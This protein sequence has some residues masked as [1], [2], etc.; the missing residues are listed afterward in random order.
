[1]KKSNLFTPKILFTVFF[2][3][4]FLYAIGQNSNNQL[5]IP[6]INAGIAKLSGKFLNLKLSDKNE[7]VKIRIGVYNPI[8]GESYYETSLSQNFDFNIDIPLECSSAIVGLS[9]QSDSTLLE[10]Y[11]IGVLKDKLSEIIID[12][13]NK[14]KPIINLK[15]GLRLTQNDMTSIGTGIQL[16]ETCY[17]WADYYKMTPTEFREYELN[18][19]L[20][21]RIKF[22][23]DSF[24]VSNEIINYLTN[25][26]NLRYFD[27]LI[28]DYKNV[29]QQSFNYANKDS[30]LHYIVTEPDTL[31]YSFLKDYNLNNPQYL[32]CYSYSSFLKSFLSIKSLNIPEIKD[33]QIDA[34]LSVVKSKIKNIV[35]FDSGLF[36]DMLIANS[37]ILQMNYKMKPLTNKQ[38]TNIQDYFKSKNMDIASILIKSN[39]IIKESLEKGQDLKVNATPYVSKEKL[40]NAIISKY[41]GKVVLV[42]FWETWCG[43][44]LRGMED[45][46]PLK[47]EFKGKEIVFVYISSIS[48][49]K[50]RW[51]AQIKAIGGEQYSFT[52]SE[53]NYVGDSFDF[54]GVPSYL[55]YD[56][57]GELKHK[58]TG[59]PGIEKMREMINELLP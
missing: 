29:A 3:I 20:K 30:S 36:Y 21:K 1:M 31:F 5:P 49:P 28:F 39:N 17:T 12:F 19:S 33:T 27:G 14:N 44:C 37:Y 10:N 51:E 35:G 57:N 45:M 16:F 8:S 58:F 9:I 52:K 23:F 43:P 47:N 48:S 18:V 59:F 22:V 25:S 50:E 42:D 46:K 11:A 4:T 32:Y 40:M 54:K 55:I 6:T 38:I 2:S 15:S 24:S 13:A 53:S 41:K 26:F 34:W 56:K 7:K